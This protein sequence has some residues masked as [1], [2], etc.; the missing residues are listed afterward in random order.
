[1]GMRSGHSMLC[2]YYAGDEPARAGALPGGYGKAARLAAASA[3]L[4]TWRICKKRYPC[5]A[6]LKTCPC[7]RQV[8][9]AATLDTASPPLKSP[10]RGRKSAMSA[11]TARGGI[12]RPWV[13]IAS[14]RLR[15]GICERAPRSGNKTGKRAHVGR[16]VL[17]AGFG[18][19]AYLIHPFDRFETDADSKVAISR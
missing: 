17:R 18:Q 10:S 1:M 19:T 13:L 11:V 2:P 15:L 12:S 16:S 8:D 5:Y 4:Q 7:E 3:N 6:L 9:S 14:L